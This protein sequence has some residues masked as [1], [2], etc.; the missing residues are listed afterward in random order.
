MTKA[1]QE[2]TTRPLKLNPGLTGEK[3]QGLEALTFN[4]NTHK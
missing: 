3:N 4:K 2:K 1:S